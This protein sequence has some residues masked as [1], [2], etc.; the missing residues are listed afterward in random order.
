MIQHEISAIFKN[1]NVVNRIRMLFTIFLCKLPLRFLLHPKFASSNFVANHMIQYIPNLIGFCILKE[2]YLFRKRI[3][4]I[5]EGL[6]LTCNKVIKLIATNTSN[7][8]NF[9]Y[10]TECDM[11]WNY[12][13]LEISKVAIFDSIQKKF[14]GM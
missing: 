1:E 3:Q 11:P 2:Q 10:K 7:Y 12:G 14:D 8:F 6:I 9:S 13:I 4:F 5:N